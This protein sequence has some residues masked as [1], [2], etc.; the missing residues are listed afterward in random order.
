MQRDKEGHTHNHMRMCMKNACQKKPYTVSPDNKVSLSPQRFTSFAS[1]LRCRCLRVSFHFVCF[2]EAFDAAHT[3]RFFSARLR[4]C[5]LIAIL[6]GCRVCFVR[7][8]YLL[9]FVRSVSLLFFF[10]N[11]LFFQSICSPF[12]IY[13][14]FSAPPR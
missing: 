8:F 11:V 12:C 2:L 6:F 3:D 1:L 9:L 7:G 13:T 10:F 4:D 14:A 5:T